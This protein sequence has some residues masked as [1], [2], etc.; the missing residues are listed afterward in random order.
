ML[1]GTFT[2]KYTHTHAHR[3]THTAVSNR[4]VLSWAVIC[5]VR[6]VMSRV[7]KK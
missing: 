3:H 5:G 6:D 4:H 2:H 1:A 7:V